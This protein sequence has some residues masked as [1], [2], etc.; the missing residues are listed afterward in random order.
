MSVT[1]KPVGVRSEEGLGADDR[2]DN[3]LERE[4]RT[5][6]GV[7]VVFEVVD[8]RAWTPHQV[9]LGG[10]EDVGRE[11]LFGDFVDIFPVPGITLKRN[12]LQ[13]CCW[14]RVFVQEARGD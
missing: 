3:V 7:P 1:V 14:G 10:I 13:S 4:V 11:L 5:V 6:W 12:G 9:N 2:V 8:C